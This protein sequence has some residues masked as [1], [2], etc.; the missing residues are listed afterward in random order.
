MKYLKSF[1]ESVENDNKRKLTLINGIVK[2]VLSNTKK[3]EN[4]H[5][6]ESSVYID[7]GWGKE[8]KLYAIEYN[9]DNR[10]CRIYYH[11]DQAEMSWL[12]ILELSYDDL[13]KILLYLTTHHPRISTYA[14]SITDKALFKMNKE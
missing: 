5:F 11:G 2:L 10:V 3:H 12:S 9:E 4:V 1:N 8:V 6:S 13:K 7:N 14:Q